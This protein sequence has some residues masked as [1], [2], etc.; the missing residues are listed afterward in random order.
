MSNGTIEAV[1]KYMVNKECHWK[2]VRE[3]AK[4]CA[5]K[6]MNATP[7]VLIVVKSRYPIEVDSTYRVFT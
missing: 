7:Q 2:D 3:K 6:V 5:S 4:L 1:F